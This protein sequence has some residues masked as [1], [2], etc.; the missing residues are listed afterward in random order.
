MQSR[1]MMA[2]KAI[3]QLGD[4]SRDAPNYCVVHEDPA[5]PENYIGNWMM[6]FGF[7]G[8]KFPKATTREMTPAEEK[9]LDD[10]ERGIQVGSLKDFNLG[11]EIR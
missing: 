6:G 1:V 5:D 2:T 8:V 4:L 3:H 10:N 9:W 7:I 11:G